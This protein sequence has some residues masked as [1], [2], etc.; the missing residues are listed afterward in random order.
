VFTLLQLSGNYITKKGMQNKRI[1]FILIF[2][3]KKKYKKSNFVKLGVN[4]KEGN[5]RKRQKT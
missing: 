1:L 5:A 3:D 2:P 4:E